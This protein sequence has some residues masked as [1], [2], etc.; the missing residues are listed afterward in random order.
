MKIGLVLGSG[1]ARGLAHIGVLKGLV[2]EEI[3]I[4]M[5]AGTSVGAIL[6]AMFALGKTPQEIESEVKKYLSDNTVNQVL[7]L[8]H[9][10]NG[11]GRFSLEGAKIWLQEKIIFTKSLTRDSLLQNYILKNFIDMVIPEDPTDFK[12]PFYAV[13]SNAQNGQERVFGEGNMRKGILASAA[14]PGVFPPVKIDDSYYIDGGVVSP[15]PISVLRERGADFVIAVGLPTQIRED[16]KFNSAMEVIIRASRIAVQKR[17]EEQIKQADFLFL[18][19]VGQIG[20]AAFDD[21]DTL[22]LTG[23]KVF[24]DNLSELKK[25][26]RTGKRKFISDKII[27]TI[28]FNQVGTVTEH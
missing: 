13:T 7:K 9:K 6:G 14:I 8:M 5:I 19:P 2:K 4:S 17:F 15:V 24:Y 23:E 16:K 20:W 18:P 10:G 22:I 21:V 11:L 28:T 3:E 26:I 25:S 12:I 1:G 27:R